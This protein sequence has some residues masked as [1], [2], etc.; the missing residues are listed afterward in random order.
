M[1]RRIVLASVPLLVAA[2]MVLGVR[3][4]QTNKRLDKAEQYMMSSMVSWTSVCGAIA[5]ELR[6]PEPWHVRRAASLVQNYCLSSDDVPRLEALLQAGEFRDAVEF[7]ITRV[8]EHH[9]PR[10][11][12]LGSYDSSSF[13]VG[14]R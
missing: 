8:Y 11:L 12:K 1:Q 10:I 2:V 9:L 13:P 4:Y 3:L 14:Y 7:A 5:A 6:A